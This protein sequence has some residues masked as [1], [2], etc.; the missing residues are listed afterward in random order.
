V[1][2]PYRPQIDWPAGTPEHIR[3]PIGY[4]TCGCRRPLAEV[5]RGEGGEREAA[6]APDPL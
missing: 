4:C 2:E 3:V 5:E 6:A 1:D